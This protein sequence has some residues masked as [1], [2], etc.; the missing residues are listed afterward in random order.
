[1][2]VQLLDMAS[3]GKQKRMPSAFIFK[4]K[5]LGKVEGFSLELWSVGFRRNTHMSDIDT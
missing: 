1:M 5:S 3:D 4:K 2:S